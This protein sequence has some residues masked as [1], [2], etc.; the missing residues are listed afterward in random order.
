M[1]DFKD[2]IYT[3][4]VSNDDGS[5]RIEVV[6]TSNWEGLNPSAQLN[7]LKTLLLLESWGENTVKLIRQLEDE[8][9]ETLNLLDCEVLE[10]WED[11]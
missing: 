6:R 9:L 2:K 7:M 10:P 4:S 11:R 1:K 3:F 8:D 5:D